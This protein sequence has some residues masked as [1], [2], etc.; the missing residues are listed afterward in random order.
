MVRKWGMMAADWEIAKLLRQVSI[1]DSYF[2][3]V[4]VM[5][6]GVVAVGR[7]GVSLARSLGE[8]CQRIT[9]VGF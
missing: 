2:L 6:T 1:D 7:H 8:Q 5:L 4:A 3:R 9:Q